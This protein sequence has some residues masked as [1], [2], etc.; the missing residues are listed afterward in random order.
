MTG[1]DGDSSSR[2]VDGCDGGGAIRD[3]WEL[4]KRENIECIWVASSLS[5]ETQ[6][7]YSEP[8]LPR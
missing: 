7:R 2:S 3:G 4:R 6:S 5:I 1:L 8:R